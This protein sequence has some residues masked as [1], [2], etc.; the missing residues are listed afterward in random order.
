LSIRGASIFQQKGF[1]TVWLRVGSGNTTAQ[2]I[3][4]KWG[5]TFCGE[6]MY[7]V[8]RERKKALIMMKHI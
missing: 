4:L 6:E 2:E 7:R 8:G 3:Y 5:Y 1:K